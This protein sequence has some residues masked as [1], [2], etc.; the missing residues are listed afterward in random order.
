[1]NWDLLRAPFRSADIDFRPGATTKDKTKAIGLAYVDKRI[2][3]DRLDEFIGPENWSV[4]YRQIGDKGVICRL[5]IYG[6]VREDVGEFAQDDVATFPTAV[7]QAFK[8]ACSA[9]G[10]GRYLYSLPQVWAEYDADRRRFTDAGMAHLRKS[11]NVQQME[12]PVQQVE[13]PS[14]T[15]SAK[16]VHTSD[17]QT[18][19]IISRIESL[20]KNLPE[21]QKKL[22]A[23][24][25]Q[26][27]MEQLIEIGK[28]LAK[29]ES[30]RLIQRIESLMLDALDADV[31]VDMPKE[32]Q[33]SSNDELASIEA[34]LVHALAEQ[35]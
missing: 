15:A 32:W 31:E 33:K 29:A 4:E 14:S 11:L 2:Y 23:N 6:V 12:K 28:H 8:R 25:Q 18:M 17:A 30:T 3:E 9:F 35:S 1:M 26:V 27:P 20:L 7:A 10:L 5:T 13:K 19:R 24:W 16:A 22:S 21:E 34:K